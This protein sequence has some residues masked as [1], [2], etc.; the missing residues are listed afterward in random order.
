MIVEAAKRHGIPETLV[1]R[2]VMR[3]SRYNPQARNHH[4]WGLMQISYP[5]A[6]SMGF[7]GTPQELLNPLTNLTYAV[8]YLA[9]AFVAAGRREDAAIRL[10]ASGY[11]DTARHRGLLGSMRTAE[12]TPVTPVAAP[13]PTAAPASFGIFGALFGPSSAP[14][15]TPQMTQA[16]PG[17]DSASMQQASNVAPQASAAASSAPS[18][19]A[20]ADG[21]GKGTGG[22]VAM[23][24]GKTGAM[25]PPKKWLRDGG[26]TVLARGEQT[27]E[28]TAAGADRSTP[29][30]NKRLAA[31]RSHK[32]TEFA[33]LDT[34][35]AA[36]AYA[37]TANDAQPAPQTAINEAIA[38]NSPP[39]AIGQR[40]EEADAAAAPTTESKSARKRHARAE[41]KMAMAKAASAKAATA[42]SAAAKPAKTVA[43]LQP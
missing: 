10:Y 33:A 21:Q 4:F 7:R 13:A 20:A 17:S 30:H 2:V 1:R 18:R 9:N 22:D 38:G 8:P 5:T 14:S 16:A 26:L 19:L 43:D 15:E 36:Q 6:R 27:V 25:A 23:V 34:P 39:P 24:A 3:E 42:K 11:Y 29:A 37:A 40:A 28:R 12:S 35:P 31:R 41:H 32:N